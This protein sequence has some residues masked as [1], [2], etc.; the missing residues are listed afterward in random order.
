M[1]CSGGGLTAA[2][3]GFVLCMQVVEVDCVLYDDTTGLKALTLQAA[4]GSL[5]TTGRDVQPSARYLSLLQAGGLRAAKLTAGMPAQAPAWLQPAPC[6]PLVCA[7]GFSCSVALARRNLL[8]VC[9]VAVPAGSRHH[10]LDN[11]YQQWLD[12]LPSYQPPSGMRAT[13]GALVSGAVLLSAASTALPAYVLTRVTGGSS[14]SSSQPDA[15]QQ[16]P[17]QQQSAAS[18]QRASSE[19]TAAGAADGNGLSESRSKP[20]T[21]EGLVLFL[22]SYTGSAQQLMWDV[23]DKLAPWLG[24][25]SSA[26]KD[27]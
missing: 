6:V 11:H 13:L 15:K 7:L 23:N 10:G 25:G 4:P 1:S 9:D 18:P 19:T 26:N 20:P 3:V 8:C 5:H 24:S 21:P 14:S 12:S 22:R 17:Q 27:L 16:L 2:L